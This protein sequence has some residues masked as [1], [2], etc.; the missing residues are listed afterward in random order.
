MRY[1]TRD[2]SQ[3]PRLLFAKLFL[4]GCGSQ[5]IKGRRLA[6]AASVFVDVCTD[7]ELPLRCEQYKIKALPQ[8]LW[9]ETLVQILLDT[10]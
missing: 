9:V 4:S 1:V 7:R 10:R 2:C 5:S 8:N 6:V 3:A